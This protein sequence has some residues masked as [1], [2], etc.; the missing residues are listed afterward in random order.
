MTS[1]FDR[2]PGYFVAAVLVVM[3]LMQT[4]LGPS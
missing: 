2:H 4:W 1:L 3:A